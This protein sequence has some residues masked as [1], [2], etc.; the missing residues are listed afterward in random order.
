MMECP[1]AREHS[2]NQQGKAVATPCPEGQTHII[3]FFP[4]QLL[5]LHSV[6]YLNQHAYLHFAAIDARDA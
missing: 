3:T 6:F 4:E 2:H 1:K 5:A